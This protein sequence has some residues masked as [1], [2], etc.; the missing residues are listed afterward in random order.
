MGD[1]FVLKSVAKL[2]D[3]CNDD[4]LPALLVKTMNN[5]PSGEYELFLE[6]DQ[7]EQVS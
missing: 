2:K 3:N 5:V 1:K 6:K 4:C 7:V